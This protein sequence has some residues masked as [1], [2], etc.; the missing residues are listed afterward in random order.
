MKIIAITFLCLVLTTLS[1]GA[2]AEYFND[3]VL[4]PLSRST[5]TGGQTQYPVQPEQ[6]LTGVTTSPSPSTSSSSGSS[7]DTNGTQS[8]GTTSATVAQP[9]E[10]TRNWA[11]YI[12]TG[13]NFTA[14]SGT[15]TV[16]SVSASNA[17]LTGDATWIGI[18]G[19]SSTDLIQVG[20]E[21][22]IVNGQLQQGV[23]YELLP[24]TSQT[25][26]EV[27][28]AAGDVIHASITQTSP[29]QWTISVENTTTGQSF[30]QPVTYTSSYSS[31]EWIE[32]APTSQAGIMPLD[33][34]GSVTF[35][36]VQAVEDGQGVTAEGAS[37]VGLANLSGHYLADV[38]TISNDSFTVARTAATSSSASGYGSGYGRGFQPDG[39]IHISYY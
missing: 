38:S 7:D 27:P 30:T 15:W 22:I 33:D 37:V 24:D 34:F 11:G 17:A 13:G 20:T 14:V 25:I 18:G 31:A 36:D 4:T 23:F 6:P 10:V 2:A 39:R 32:E 16:P 35:H 1:F 29:G 19:T 12:Q 9:S 3:A 26:T 21:N 28:A 8:Q 5:T